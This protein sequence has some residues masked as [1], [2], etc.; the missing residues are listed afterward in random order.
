MHGFAIVRLND[1]GSATAEYYEGNNAAVP[2]YR[3]TL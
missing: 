1:D 3:E 2:M